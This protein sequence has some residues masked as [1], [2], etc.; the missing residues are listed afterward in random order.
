MYKKAVGKPS[1]DASTRRKSALSLFKE[2]ELQ[3]LW[4]DACMWSVLGYL[5]G[6][7]NLELP[8]DWK[9]AMPREP[10]TADT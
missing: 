4:Q 7:Y 8:E 10:G 6:N 5:R 9:L 3:D 1:I 2:Q